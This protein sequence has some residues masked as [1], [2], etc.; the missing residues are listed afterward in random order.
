[1]E[2]VDMQ[3][4]LEANAKQD[5]FSLTSPG[6][7]SSSRPILFSKNRELSF[8]DYDNDGIAS[9]LSNRNGQ[10]SS[11][12]RKVLNNS[13]CIKAVAYDGSEFHFKKRTIKPILTLERPRSNKIYRM[14]NE[15]ERTNYNNLILCSQIGGQGNEEV[16]EV[17]K[18]CSG[19][20]LWVDKYR[21]TKY[22]DLLSEEV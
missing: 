2:D 22:I 7:M 6:L 13:F 8:Y 9:P 12:R 1:M 18:D 20:I 19:N 3:Q 11:K 21:P 4:W 5:N 17:K 14:I 15:I 10:G 16:G